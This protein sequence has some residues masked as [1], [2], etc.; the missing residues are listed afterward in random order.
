[1]KWSL[2]SEADRDH[3]IDSERGKANGNALT[4]REEEALTWRLGS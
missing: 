4:D 3:A 1:M 2:E